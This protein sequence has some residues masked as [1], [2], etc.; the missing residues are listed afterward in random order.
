MLKTNEI[1]YNSEQEDQQVA[2]PTLFISGAKNP[3]TKAFVLL[4]PFLDQTNTIYHY[5]L[6][7]YYLANG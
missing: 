4:A 7:Y 6:H 3:L 5:D 1:A 2:P